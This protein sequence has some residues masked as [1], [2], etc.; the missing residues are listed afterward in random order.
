[1]TPDAST[2]ILFVEDDER[3]RQLV[4]QGLEKQYWVVSA[5]NGEEA[6]DLLSAHRPLMS[7]LITEVVL[8][9]MDGLELASRARHLTPDLPVLYMTQEDEVSEAVRQ[10]VANTNNFYLMKPFDH[11]YLLLKVG[12]ALKD[13]EVPRFNTRDRHPSHPRPYDLVDRHLEAWQS[14]T[15]SLSS[16]AQQRP[17]RRARRSVDNSWPP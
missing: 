5:R 14:V 2:V 15:R 13:W 6:W 11:E 12:A 10:G 8:P 9:D 7:L 17:S 16:T 4:M 3:L 1:M